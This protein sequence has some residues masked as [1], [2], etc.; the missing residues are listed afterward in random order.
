MGNLANG[1]QYRGYGDFG[2]NSI[3]KGVCVV[4]ISYYKSSFLSAARNAE[5]TIQLGE[6]I[7]GLIA[8][9]T[10]EVYYIQTTRKLKKDEISRL[11]WL[12]GAQNPLHT[13]S[14]KSTFGRING[15]VLEFGPRMN[16]ETADSS[17]A[18][19]IMHSCNLPTIKRV[20]K[21]RRYKFIAIKFSEEEKSAVSPLLHDKMT[22]CLY[23]KR[24]TS[25]NTGK[26]PMPVKYIPLMEE[27]IEAL[28]QANKKY[29][30]GFD[31]QDLAYL[32][33]LYGEVLKRNPN[34]VEWCDLGNSVSEH[35][36]HGLFRAKIIIDGKVMPFTLMEVI[37]GTLKNR[38]N[39]IIAFHDNA[40]AIR[41]FTITVL[42]PSKPGLPSPVR[43]AT[44]LYHFVLTVE[45]H[46][47]P[48]LWEAYAGAA[49]GGGGRRRDNQALGR[50]GI[51]RAAM[52]LFLAGQLRLPG[53]I[54]PW[55]DLTWP[56]DPRTETPLNF[57]IKATKGCFDDGN[58][59]GEPVTLLGAESFAF[60]IGEQRWENIKPIMCTGG[61]GYLLDCLKEKHEPE[62]G[63][64]VVK[65]GGLAYNIGFGGGS[66][67][68]MMAGDSSAELDFKSVQ[69][70]NGEM[71][72]KTNE[73]LLTCNYM[74]AQSPIETIHDQGAGGNGNI[75]KE[76]VG[77]FGAKIRL[78]SIPLG[79]KTMSTCEII[80]AEYQENIGL[81]IKAER[82]TEFA[83]ICEREKC[84]YAAVG[85]ITGDGKF[86]IIDEKDGTVPYDLKIVDIFSN[87]PQKTFIDK[88]VTL[89][90]EALVLPETSTVRSEY[91][92]VARLLGVCSK[93]WMADIVDGSVT[94]DVVDST[95]AG[96]LGLPISEHSLIAP[97]LLERV[98][99]VN[100]VS[101]RPTIGLISP[102]AMARMVAADALLKVV[103]TKITKRTEVKASANWML[104][105]KLPGGLAWLW[106]AA[107]ALREILDKIG[108][109]IDGGKDSLSMAATVPGEKEKVRSLSTLVITTYAACV[110]YL[111][112][113]TAEIKL[114]GESVLLF[115][116]LAKGAT[117]L[118][119][120]ALAQVHKQVGNICPDVDY[121]EV[122]NESFDLIQKLLEQN[123]ILSGLGRGRGG[124]LLTASKMA[125]AS[126]CGIDIET[127]HAKASAVEI[128]Y[129]EELGLVIEC[130]PQDEAVIRQQFAQLELDD[131]VYH[132]GKTTKEKIIKVAHNGKQVLS[133]DMRAL[134]DIWRDTSFQMKM[135]HAP[136][137]IIEEERKNLYDQPTPK[138]VLTFN[139]DEYPLVIANYPGK[140]RIAILREEGTNSKDEAWKTCFLAGFEPVDVHMTDLA[141]GK[142][143][144]RNF[145][146]IFYPGGFSFKDILGAARGWAG[147]FK[148]NELVAKEFAEFYAR[149]DTISFGPCN[150]CQLM[151]LLG[152]IPWQMAEKS[153]PLFTTNV[154]ET[155]CSGF[156][157]VKIFDS[158]SIWL[159]D[160]AGSTLGVHIAHGEGKFHCPDQHVL[161]VILGM[162]LAPIR[163]VDVTD[164]PTMAYPFN[165]N[166][167][168][169]AITAICDPTG[170]HLAFME[171][172]ERTSLKRQYLTW[173]RE[174]LYQNSPWIRMFQNARIWCQ[175]HPAATV[176]AEAPLIVV[177]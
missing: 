17:N 118:G 159:K 87:Y 39:S 155:F 21:S 48:C 34:D 140:P 91:D 107:V 22:E 73:V 115:I 26:R 2:K 137:I 66:A 81:L 129:N 176:E 59:F 105:A 52:A 149:P 145:R 114:P 99:E 124:L 20:E 168:E 136:R 38:E 156:P 13:L 94:G 54:L 25:F 157:T 141:S 162:N 30:T 68:S 98:G 32:T 170:R 50:G 84:P 23:P 163:F 177:P 65:I 51:V 24:L 144:L 134:R 96:S 131:I 5:L 31:E 89:P 161:R 90:L 152:I 122:V 3:G 125:F 67:S 166:G 71:A 130:R 121:P 60:R 72:A 128:L 42:T 151:A 19:N 167:S 64:I 158:P 109:D 108:V 16:F 12:L 147:V 55:E 6:L 92:L 43:M 119:G 44:L 111:L 148:F 135:R 27:G 46:N 7:P 53:Y 28:R 1:N 69:R 45:T 77:H 37:Q 57:F 110:D 10:E 127:N 70:A 80:V 35:S 15:N 175:Q 139:P 160:M 172:P 8:I 126:N 103:F 33:Y 61:Y 93:E 29:G 86:V 47:H 62:V 41:G 169:K 146:A 79:D 120:S 78:R 82:F 112:R 150:G 153:Q 165:P 132:L 49:T 36:R 11:E 174:W 14:K 40:S 58:Q 173:P 83:A 142:I 104:A 18:V 116:D 100:T 164:R 123:L 85:V 106:D 75:L 133:E 76:L 74:G 9:Q 88:R 56:Y 138:Y 102:Q 63:W 171:H 117:R 97:G 154:S 113:A 143:S 4:I 101:Y 95:R